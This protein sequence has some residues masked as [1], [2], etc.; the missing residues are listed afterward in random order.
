MGRTFFSFELFL[1]PLEFHD[2]FLD[3]V[4]VDTV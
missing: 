2:W 3:L 1:L 4:E